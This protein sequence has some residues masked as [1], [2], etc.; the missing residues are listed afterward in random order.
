M[1]PHLGRSA[2]LAVPALVGHVVEFER[3][4]EARE[5]E[6]A[7]A[8]AV[9]A[10]EVAFPAASVTEVVVGLLAQA[11]WDSAP[12]LC[13][14]QQ[15]AHQGGQFAVHGS[16]CLRLPGRGRHRT[17]REGLASLGGAVQQRVS[18]CSVRVNFK[19]EDSPEL[20]VLW[21]FGPAERRRRVRGANGPLGPSLAS[22]RAPTVRAT[23]DNA[24]HG[25]GGQDVLRKAGNSKEGILLRR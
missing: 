8:A 17:A 6:G 3:R 1:C 18:P 12:V 11:G 14:R 13:Y 15:D 24:V 9:A 21:S 4:F 5:V 7:E 25:R 22:A 10:E 16:G 2:R 23:R 19:I 20:D